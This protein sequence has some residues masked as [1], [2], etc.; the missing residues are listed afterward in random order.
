LPQNCAPPV[1][2]A[3]QTGQKVRRVISSEN[4]GITAR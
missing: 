4:A 3:P 2:V 1:S